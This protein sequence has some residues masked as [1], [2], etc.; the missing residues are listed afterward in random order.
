VA[1][2]TTRT[3]TPLVPHRAPT[4]RARRLRSCGGRSQPLQA[5]MVASPPSHLDFATCSSTKSSS[6]WEREAEPHPV[7]QVLCPLHR[8]RWRQQRHQ[9]PLLPL[10][11]GPNSLTW[12]ESRDKHSIDKWD[13]LKEQFTSNFAGAMGRSG[14]RMDLAMV[15]QEQGRPSASTCAASSTSTLP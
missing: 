4:T 10:L 6:L 8:E 1:V 5:T 12:L 13:Q 14:T 3:A 11:P 7:A 9:V 15:K 2:E